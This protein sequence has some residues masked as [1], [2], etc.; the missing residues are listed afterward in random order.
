MERKWVRYIAWRFLLFLLLL[1]YILLLKRESTSF[2]DLMFTFCPVL[3]LGWRWTTGST[4][5]SWHCGSA[6]EICPKFFAHIRFADLMHCDKDF[7]EELFDD[8]RFLLS[9]KVPSKCSNA[10]FQGPR[11]LRGL[12]G[13]MGPVG[14]R[15]SS[16][17]LFSL[18]RCR[19]VSG[20]FF[21]P[22]SLFVPR[23]SL[24]SEASLASLALLERQWVSQCLYHKNRKSLS[25]LVSSSQLK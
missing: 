10:V 14:D 6:G 25:V 3:S 8:N 23:A 21:W 24:V 5:S 19:F 1:F 17:Y 2:C 11:G 15:V 9:F 20:C 18:S 12:Q 7:F 16:F 4:R 22:R 13:P